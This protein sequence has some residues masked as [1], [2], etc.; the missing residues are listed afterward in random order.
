METRYSI[1]MYTNNLSKKEQILCTKSFE[2]HELG[3]FL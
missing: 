1:E 3:R 2:V